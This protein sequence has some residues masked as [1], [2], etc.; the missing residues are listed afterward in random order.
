MAKEDP[1]QAFVA[2]VFMAIALVV[3]VL[4]TSDPVLKQAFG[5]GLAFVIFALVAIIVGLAYKFTK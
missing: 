2:L 1:L 4:N 5:F 3:V